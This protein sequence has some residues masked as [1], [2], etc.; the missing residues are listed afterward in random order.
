MTKSVFFIS[1]VKGVMDGRN[2]VLEWK[3]R[4]YVTGLESQGYKVH[5]PLRD[6][7][8]TDITGGMF[9]CRTNFQAIIDA[10]EI[11]IW[12]DEASAG[13]KFDM[14]GV[15]MLCQM[16]GMKKKIVIA[17]ESEMVDT[18]PKSFH[19]VFKRLVAQE[20]AIMKAAKAILV[21]H[22]DDPPCTARLNPDGYCPECRYHP[23]MQSKCFYYYCPNCQIPLKDMACPVCQQTYEKPA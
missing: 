11:H 5:W 18:A 3:L 17:N 16:L 6:T 10:K 7:E 13:S 2:P 1:P 14:G 15:F 12:Y 22:H 8:Q 9:I 23:D 21:L 19:Q 4:R 20:I